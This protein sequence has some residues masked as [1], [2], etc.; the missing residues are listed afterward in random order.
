M[1]AGTGGSAFAAAHIT[2]AAAPSVL[3]AP[4]ITVARA[5]ALLAVRAALAARR[6]ALGRGSALA[7]HLVDG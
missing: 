1:E 4:H 2:T 7:W 6:D 5:A 3:A